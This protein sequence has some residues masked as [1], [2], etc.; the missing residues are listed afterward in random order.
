MPKFVFFSIFIARE[1]NLDYVYLT[2][3]PLP[4]D[5]E[6][7]IKLWLQFDAF[8]FVDIKMEWIPQ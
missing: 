5:C 2:F 1:I 3:A 6:I 8:V 7:E 4:D